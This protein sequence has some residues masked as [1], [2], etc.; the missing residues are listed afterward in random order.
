MLAR[1][2]L[3]RDAGTAVQLESETDG[4]RNGV[5]M[6][7][8]VRSAPRAGTRAGEERAAATPSVSEAGA[9]STDK[10]ALRDG[11]GPIAAIY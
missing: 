7:R 5:C 10:N 9:R 2:K 11:G 8:T 6:A 4:Q 1:S 3:C